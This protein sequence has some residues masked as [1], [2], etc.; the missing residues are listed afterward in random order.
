MDVNRSSACLAALVVLFTACSAVDSACSGEVKLAPGVSLQ[1]EHRG[2]L[3]EVNRPSLALVSEVKRTGVRSKV[4]GRDSA[5]VDLVYKIDEVF[6]GHAAFAGREVRT[7]AS[8]EFPRFLTG[9]SAGVPAERARGVWLVA[10]LEGE[11]CCVN[12][13]FGGAYL[14][15][16]EAAVREPIPF[17]DRAEFDEVVGLGRLLGSVADRRRN[18]ED[19]RPACRAA[20]LDDNELTTKWAISHLWRQEGDRLA[21]DLIKVWQRPGQ[22][23]YIQIDCD[24]L[25]MSSS[26]RGKWRFSAARKK[27]LPA[28]LEIEDHLT[29][30][31]VRR[32]YLNELLQNWEEEGYEAEVLVRQSRY[33]W[34]IVSA[35]VLLSGGG[36]APAEEG[37]SRFRGPNGSGAAPGASIPLN[38]TPENTLWRVD[39]GGVGH[40]SPVLEGDR[41][42]VVAGEPDS[43]NIRLECWDAFTGRRLWQAEQPGEPTHLHA[44]NSY[45]SGTPAVGGGV[46]AMSW[47]DAKSFYLAGYSLDGQELW[48]K[49]LG[50]YDSR[51]GYCRS[52]IIEDGVVYLASNQQSG[53]F[54][55]AVN[56]GDGQQRW[57][58]E[59]TPGVASYDTPVVIPTAAGGRALVVG[60]SEIGMDALDLASGDVVWTAAG[61]FPQR[62]VAS[63][64][65]AGGMVLEASG[66][67]GGGKLLVGVR[68][69]TAASPEPEV[70]VK[71][72]KAV[73][74]VSTPLA[75]DGLLVMWHDRGTVAA[76]DLATGQQLWLERIGG[77]YFSSPVNVGGVVWNVSMDGQAVALEVSRDGCRVLAKNELGEGAEATPAVVG[78]RMYVRTQKS[79][80][81]IGAPATAVLPLE[82]LNALLAELRSA[83]GYYADR[84]ADAP[85][86]VRSLQDV[87]RLPFTHKDELLSGEHG[88][89]AANRTYPLSRYVRFHQTSGSRG[90]PLAVRDTA[91]DW[92]WWIEGWQYVLDAAGVTPDD[93]ALLAFSFGPF[94]GFWS[95]FDALAARGVLT[96]PGGGMGSQGRLDLIRRTEANV[97]LCTPNYAMRLAEVAAEQQTRL[98][99]LPVE[100]IIVAGEPG[101]SV[102]AVRERIERAWGARVLDHTGATE[103]GPWGYGEHAGREREGRGVYINESQ[104]L[105]EFVSVE[106]G[107]PAGEGELSHLVLTTLG[108]AGSPVIRYRTG[109]LV[110]P[111]W[112]ADGDNRFVFLEGGVISR[113]DDMMIIRGVNVFPTAIDQILRGFPEVVEYRM[114]ARRHGEMDELVVEV[115]DHLQDPRRIA[116]E[117][118]LRLG[119]TI[120]VRL[121]ASMSLPRSD[122]KAGFADELEQQLP[123]ALWQYEHL[124]QQEQQRLR[125][126]AVVVFHEKNWEGCGGLEMTDEIRLAV[127]A[128]V[129]LVTLGLK[130]QYFD[131]V[132]SVLVYPEAY[133][134]PET[135]SPGGGVIVEHES[136]RLG[137][138]WYRGPVV[139]SWSDVQRAGESRNMGRSLVAHEFA[140]QLD[141]LNGRNADGVPP[142]DKPSDA[143]AWVATL[144]SALG[145]LRRACRR[146]DRPVMDCYGATDRSEFF[147]VSSEVFFQAPHRLVEREPALYNALRS[148]Y[149]QD[150]QRWGAG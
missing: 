3:Q 74:Y 69:P 102:P 7:R 75:V 47:A 127:A 133:R 14:P 28:W 46:V 16:Y 15:I 150:P 134:A 72:T 18:G 107:E 56:A 6:C 5:L 136:A 29:F 22:S 33:W 81:C 67:G 131:H 128:Q 36:L 83:G 31:C 111:S 115:E 57:R 11:L 145:R 144:E 105:A 148:Y 63:P 61:V 96:I 98:T 54:V 4:T 48:S 103:V 88:A 76:V 125:D 82:K 78:N 85:D 140:H 34:W 38:W 13:M 95:A 24:R 9:R 132:L 137:E 141:M 100:K 114:T 91:E 84:L 77:N 17:G 51:H 93:R 53:A 45:A 124:S 19:P 2:Y 60:S 101:G 71:I 70:A 66:S 80:V 94:V 30:S 32:Y 104:F 112:T 122:G 73:P 120:E 113:A 49:K 118:N 10:E 109:D 8:E 87:R 40:G 27:M 39:L 50:A 21:D 89:E 97:L 119:L 23:P 79:L 92:R 35:L 106:T 139:L 59:L 129:S 25:L 12:A 68:P 117:L 41:L 44:M 26:H 42:F 138:A 149:G 116:K 130:E 143:E 52:P 1:V 126:T 65:F 146:G 58:R 99:E 142:I 135:R 123:A 86:E 37:W 20:L 64:I 55:L 108:R 110:R 43:A 90:R 121:A 147:A 62:C